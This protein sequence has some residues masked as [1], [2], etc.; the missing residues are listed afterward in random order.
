MLVQIPLGVFRIWGCPMQKL[1]SAETHGIFE[2]SFSLFSACRTSMSFDELGLSNAMDMSVFRPG[3]SQDCELFRAEFFRNYHDL[4]LWTMQKS[5]LEFQ[6]W[7]LSYAEISRIFRILSFP[8]QT[9]LGIY[10]ILKFSEPRSPCPCQYGVETCEMP[11]EFARKSE[12]E[13][14]NITGC[15]LIPERVRHVSYRAAMVLIF[16]PGFCFA[17]VAARFPLFIL[18]GKGA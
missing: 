15:R 4:G 6:D 7:G 17:V 12:L 3:N 9:S 10:R 16:E 2:F 8:V 18:C 11:E 1:L 5:S 13:L 14:S